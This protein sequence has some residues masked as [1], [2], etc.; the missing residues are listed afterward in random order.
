MTEE[1]TNIDIVKSQILVA[2]GMPLADDEI[3][4]GDQKNVQIDGFA[5]QCRV[6][7]EDPA[8]N[9]MPDYGRVTHYRSSGGMEFAWMPAARVFRSSGQSILRFTADESDNTRQAIY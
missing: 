7:T 3:G 8:N 6:T 9:F 5:I 1:I 4:L 2:Q